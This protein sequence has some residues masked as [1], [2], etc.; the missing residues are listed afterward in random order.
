[1]FVLKFLIAAYLLPTL[2]NSHVGEY[3][4]LY[5]V[6][7]D[8]YQ[9]EPRYDERDYF[10][11]ESERLRNDERKYVRKKSEELRRDYPENDVDMDV[12]FE[13]DD[14][15][16]YCKV[17]KMFQYNSRDIDLLFDALYRILKFYEKHWSKIIVDALFG[18]RGGEGSVRLAL[19]VI[20]P[21]HNLYERLKTLNDR[22]HY[23]CQKIYNNIK[24]QTDSYSQQFLS[25]IDKPFD[26]IRP[27]QKYNQHLVWN[28]I[29]PSKYFAN[30][31]S[32]SQSSQGI[33]T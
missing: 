13:K 5:D 9:G 12:L 4:K 24:R 32:V 19:K 16:S 25:I 8:D 21:E 22:F 1:M 10:D 3:R 11:V 15:P 14:D 6:E 18:L 33:I 31:P 23:I 29:D 20:S 27:W 26:V 28:H 2:C 7:H 17:K 30:C